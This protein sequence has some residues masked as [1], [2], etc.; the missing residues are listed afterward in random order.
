MYVMRKTMVPV[1][2]R[3]PVVQPVARALKKHL[4]KFTED[5]SSPDYGTGDLERALIGLLV[6]GKTVV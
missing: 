3:N 4:K 5:H 2:N 1:G 6:V